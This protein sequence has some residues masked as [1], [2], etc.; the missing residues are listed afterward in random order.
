MPRLAE[1]EGEDLDEETGSENRK[2]SVESVFL[3]ALR[4]TYT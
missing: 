1:H 3:K 4:G 2:S